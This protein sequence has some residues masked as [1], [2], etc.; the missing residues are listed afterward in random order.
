MTWFRRKT[1]APS[2]D[3]L[4]FETNNW[5]FHGEQEPGQ[6]RL[7]ETA[8]HDAVLLHYFGIPPNLPAA[9]TLEEISAVYASGVAPAGGKIVEC[10]ISEFARCPAVRLLLKV[11]QKPSGM[12][13]QGAVTVP[14]RDFSFVVKI[15]CAEVGTTGVREAILFEKRLRAGDMPNI[16][17]PGNPFPG[18]NPDAPEHDAAFPS[19]PLSRLRRL[20]KEIENSATLDDPIRDLPK[21][22]LSARSP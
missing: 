15:Q 3:S 12:M 9:G 8:D 5:K 6:M 21:F 18:W 16:E 7:W 10:A 20:L 2:I 17:T 4:R 19:H 11:P 22:R 1:P 13:Y 14:F